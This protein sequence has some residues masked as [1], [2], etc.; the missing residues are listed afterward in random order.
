MKK[1]S[2]KV[3]VHLITAMALTL[4]LCFIDEGYYNFN[5]MLDWNNWLAFVMY[6][7]LFWAFQMLL[8][9]LCQLSTKGT[10]QTWLSTF[11]GSILALLL[12]IF[13]VINIV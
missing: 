2:K 10:L 12:V 11:S 3:K 5:W 1:V 4:F 6:V 7:A 9:K 13:I 8:S